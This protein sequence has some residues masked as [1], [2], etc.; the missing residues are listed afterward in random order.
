[1][2]GLHAGFWCVELPLKFFN[3]RYITIQTPLARGK[4]GE[5][6]AA[7]F[8][9]FFFFTVKLKPLLDFN[10]LKQILN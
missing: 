2:S 3:D 6:S 9:F 8:F 5:T 1:M 7:D 10:E 4:S